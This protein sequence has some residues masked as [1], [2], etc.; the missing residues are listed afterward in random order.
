MMLVERLIEIALTNAASAAVLTVLVVVVGRLIKRPEV[1]HVLWLVVLLRLLV[2]PA[3]ELRLPWLGAPQ[4][5]PGSGGSLMPD[6]AP[7]TD[8]S[9][10][11][12]ATHSALSWPN[13]PC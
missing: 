5:V 9:G 4:A 11:S 1:I 8:V 3:F 13:L 7:V 12:G 6:L 10:F 2:P